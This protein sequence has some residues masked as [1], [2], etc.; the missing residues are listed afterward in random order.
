LASVAALS[1]LLLGS[2]A[3]AMD[4]HSAKPSGKPES[5]LGQA[6]K[7][8]LLD[9]ARPDWNDSNDNTIHIVQ[10]PLEGHWGV[11]GFGPDPR[12]K[13]SG[14]DPDFHLKY[15]ESDSGGLKAI[16][17]K[18]V[19]KKV[20]GGHSDALLNDLYDLVTSAT[21]T[22]DITSLY[23]LSGRYLTTL[24]KALAK[25]NETGYHDLEAATTSDIVVRIQYSG[26]TA[27]KFR[28]M[29]EEIVEGLKS[30]GHVKVYLGYFN[31]GLSWNHAKIVAVDGAKALVTGNNLVEED[32]LNH[33]PVHDLGLMVEGSAAT[34]AH[35]FADQL[36][37]MTCQ[38]IGNKVY[39]W[40][41][42][43]WR[44]NGQAVSK[45]DKQGCPVHLDVRPPHA[46]GHTYVMSL[47]RRGYDS[48]SGGSSQ[49][50][51]D[52]A[53]EALI[54]AA[55]HTIRIAQARMTSDNNTFYYMGTSGGYATPVLEAIVEAMARGVQVQVVFA[56]VKPA[57]G[58][59]DAGYGGVDPAEFVKVVRA[60]AVA[61]FFQDGD[62]ETGYPDVDKVMGNL[63]VASVKYSDHDA[64]PAATH[65]KFVMADDQAYYV[66]SHNLYDWSLYEYGY[67]VDSQTA[68]NEM[69]QHYWSHLWKYSSPGAVHGG[70]K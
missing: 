32:Y 9:K 13:G 20:L 22:I 31:T 21:H 17:L 45:G 62:V 37:T 25:L 60:L 56:N 52:V 42:A 43:Y 10:T 3:Q 40:R 58:D 50:P 19:D 11:P 55:R 5:S 67:L 26:V 18:M 14:C 68:A 64:Y 51:S 41:G 8:A 65:A 61:R 46:L 27:K 12:C 15:A 66:G 4:G 48:L 70:Q 36:W 2:A 69:L 47:P 29:L 38:N 16:K 44:Y 53:I 49:Q 39:V 57:V 30:G 24:R 33:N 28:G 35:R 59:K 6:V 54:R 1:A 7:Q 63:S 34:E 23:P